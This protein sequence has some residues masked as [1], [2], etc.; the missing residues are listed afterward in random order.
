MKKSL[1]KSSSATKIKNEDLNELFSELKSEYLESFPE[2]IAVIEKLWQKK[3]RRQ[4]EDEFH[5]M[6]GTGTTYGVAEVSNVAEIMEA[7]CYQGHPQLG[8]AVL[9]SLELFKKVRS[10]SSR[11]A[12]YELEK[13]KMY[14][15]LRKMY[16][17]LESA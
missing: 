2:K 4:L 3:D 6:K 11:S 15:A 5:K 10:H 7:M 8:F 12:T 1:S 16:D 13:D 9:I 17:Q 14:K